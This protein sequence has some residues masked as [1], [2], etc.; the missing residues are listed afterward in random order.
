MTRRLL[1]DTGAL[2][3]LLDR[4]QTRHRDFVDYF[5]AWDGRV[6]STEAVLTETTHL[7]AGVANG[8]A[9]A[10]DFFLRGGAVLVPASVESLSR[11]RNLM[12]KYDDLPMDFADASLVVLGEE[13]DTN[14]VL[15]TD[16][17]DFAVYRLARDRGFEIVP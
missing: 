15:T 2:V 11:C 9:A 1:L 4:S 13:L 6:V 12:L 16:R 8:P 17:R 10:I 14:L 7:L 3:S 5:K